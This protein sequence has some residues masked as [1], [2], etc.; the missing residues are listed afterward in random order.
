VTLDIPMVAPTQCYEFKVR[1]R[2]PG[3]ATIERSLHGTI[4]RLSEK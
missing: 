4:H 2:A 3:G 1:L